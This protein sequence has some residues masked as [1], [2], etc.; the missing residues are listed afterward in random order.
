[1]AKQPKIPKIKSLEAYNQMSDH[2]LVVRGTAVQTGT[3]GWDSADLLTLTGT[4]GFEPR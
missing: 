3:G 2:D 4:Q 1:M